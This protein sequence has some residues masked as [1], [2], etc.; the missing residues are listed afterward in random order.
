VGAQQ[1][2]KEIEPPPIG[3]EK[4]RKRTGGEGEESANTV[5]LGPRDTLQGRLDIR[6][7]LQI[8]GNVEGDLRAD[9]SVLI[10]PSAVVKASIEGSNVIVRGHVVGTITAKRRLTLGGAGRLDGNVRVSRLTVED[11]ATL[12]GNVTMGGPE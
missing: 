7:D 4:V 5:I 6:G 11:G 8:A 1:R 2:G 10:E 9:G 12:N 3:T